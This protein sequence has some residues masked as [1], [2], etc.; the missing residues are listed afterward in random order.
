MFQQLDNAQARLMFERLPNSQRLFTL[1]P[2][3]VLAD[4]LR[5]EEL[6][7]VFLSYQEGDAFW[8]HG[9]HKASIP[10]TSYF[11]LQSPYGYGGPVTNNTD[12]N[13]LA[14]AWAEHARWCHQEGILAEFVRFHPMADN[15]K[16]YGG[17]SKVDRLTVALSLEGEDITAS[18]QTRVRTA[19]RKATRGGVTTRWERASVH[20][21]RFAQFYRQAMKDIGADE[22]YLFS[23][24]Y[25]CALATSQNSWLGICQ[26]GGSWLAAGLFL[27]SGD[28]LEYHL[29]A[30][31]QV[32]KSIGA[33][34]LLLHSAAEWAKKTRFRWLYL[35]GGTD[36]REDNPL[37]FFKAGFSQS[38]KPF[39]IGHFVH[40]RPEYNRLKAEFLT[41]N[42]VNSRVLFYR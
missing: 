21:E 17:D 41:I 12:K 5:D 22:Y 11:D 30:T 32:G 9:L 24:P 14:R 39:R 8:L 6:Q 2:E 28:V 29:S 33:T 27:A 26:Q 10:G 40:M 34:N 20:F 25:F 7:T 1:S 31:T 3:Y 35:G 37:L 13:F 42:C 4:E 16:F 19:I 38:R 23:D 15:W 18:Y 36:A